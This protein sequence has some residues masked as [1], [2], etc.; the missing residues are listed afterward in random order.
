MCISKKQ[1]K[2][3]AKA[4]LQPNGGTRPN[5]EANWPY[6]SSVTGSCAHRHIR[7]F[8][9]LCLSNQLGLVSLESCFSS[10][11]QRPKT[12]CSKVSL[13]MPKDIPSKVWMFE[14]KRRMAAGCSRQLRQMR[15]V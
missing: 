6:R 2:H 11:A 7:V 4:R 1:W 13:R 8:G 5:S 9:L 15:T 10:Q 12:P 3:V 14:L